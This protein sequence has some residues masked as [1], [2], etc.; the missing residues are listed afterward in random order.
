MLVVKFCPLGYKR[1][2]GSLQTD[3][4]H[5]L[6]HRLSFRHRVPQ[7]SLLT[8]TACRFRG[9][10]SRLFNALMRLKLYVT[11]GDPAVVINP[12]SAHLLL[13]RTLTLDMIH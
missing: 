10:S 12:S 6:D 3:L 4:L 5:A 2:M 9:G 11:A 7:P 13:T 8:S 1:A